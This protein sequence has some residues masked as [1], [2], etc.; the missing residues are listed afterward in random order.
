MINEWREIAWDFFCRTFGLRMCG[1]QCCSLKNLQ[2]VVCVLEKARVDNTSA[3]ALKSCFNI[4]GN[5]TVSYITFIPH[6]SNKIEVQWGD[7]LVIPM[8]VI[9]RMN[10]KT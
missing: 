3:G 2:C 4:S 7:Y 8:I 10:G 9:L 5:C 1:A 6:L